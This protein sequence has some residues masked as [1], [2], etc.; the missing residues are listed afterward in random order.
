M[1]SQTYPAAFAGTTF[2]ASGA[3]SIYI[4]DLAPST[5]YTITGA[6]TPASAT[7]D[8]A[9]VLTFADAGTGNITVSAGASGSVNLTSITVTP[10]SASVITLAQ[11]AVHG[12]LWLFGWI[13]LKLHVLGNLGFQCAECGNHQQFRCGDW[14][15]PGRCEY[16]CHQRKH[17][18]PGC[19]HGP[20]FNAAVHRSDT[21]IRNSFGR[22]Y[23]AIQGDR[24]LQRF[25]HF[26]L[27]ASVTWSS[28]NTAMATVNSSGLATA[29]AQ[30][31]TNILVAG[32]LIQAQAA[33]TVIPPLGPKPDSAI[34]PSSLPTPA[35]STR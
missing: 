15:G 22:H 28:S 27:T 29:M 6:G 33:V 32:S 1:F 25:E 8:N 2:P 35:S 20:H 9:G 18:G 26:G 10:S 7:T 24:N 34:S 17:H 13:Q 5:T 16:H 12:Y 3:T 31:R 4:S 19:G 30:G 23:P 21:R 11:P 14:C